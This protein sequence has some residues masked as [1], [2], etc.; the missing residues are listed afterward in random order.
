MTARGEKFLLNSGRCAI[1]QVLIRE[2]LSETDELCQYAL[3]VQGGQ[4][5][6]NTIISQMYAY[7]YIYTYTHS[8]HNYHVYASSSN[9]LIMISCQGPL[10]PLPLSILFSCTCTCRFDKSSGR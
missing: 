10:S 5:Y 6:I 7:K 4:M 2:Q 9:F 3:Y 1:V 8:Y